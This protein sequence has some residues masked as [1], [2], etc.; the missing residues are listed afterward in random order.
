MQKQRRLQA[1][2]N[3]VRELMGA[4]DFDPASTAQVIQAVHYYD[5]ATN[6]LSKPWTGRVFLN[7]P[8]G[9]ENGESNQGVWSHQLIE[10][11]TDGITVEAV[12]F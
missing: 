9:Q 12:L 7:P 10:Q 3:L 8:Y 11:Y 1:R 4:I 2:D 6:G 5:K